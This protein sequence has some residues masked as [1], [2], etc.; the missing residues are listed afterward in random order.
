MGNVYR[1]EGYKGFL[2]T[3]NNAWVFKECPHTLNNL[4]YVCFQYYV[5]NVDKLEVAKHNYEHRGKL[6]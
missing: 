1:N 3:K 2:K 4:E 5:F 6:H